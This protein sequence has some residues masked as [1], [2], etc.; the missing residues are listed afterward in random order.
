MWIKRWLNQFSLSYESNKKDEK[1][2]TKQ[3]TDEQ[4]KLEMVIKIWDLCENEEDY[5]G[6]DL[7]KK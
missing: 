4:L 1:R 7:W 5:G 6:N 3:R 2:K